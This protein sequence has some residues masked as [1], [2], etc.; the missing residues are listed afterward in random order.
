MNSACEL[1]GYCAA[2]AVTSLCA[3]QPLIPTLAYAA[4]DHEPHLEPLE[5]DDVDAAT[6]IGRDRLA[7][8]DME[9]N[10]A[11][12][13]YEGKVPIG[14][15]K[16]HAIIMEIRCYSFPGSA[17]TIAVPYSRKRSGQ[18][19]VHSPNLVFWKNGGD[20]DMHAAMESFFLGV[21]DHK[22]GFR[23]WNEC[24]DESK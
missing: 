8:N 17:A 14:K 13:S 7:S 19:L 21:A 20:C 9:A 1:A 23:I 18:L 15:R 10:D 22:V 5:H 6:A 24:L 12:L 16:F 4:P 3:G 11:V 2:Q